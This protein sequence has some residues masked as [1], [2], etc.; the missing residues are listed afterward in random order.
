MQAHSTL[1]GHARRLFGSL[2]A[3]VRASGINFDKER[4]QVLWT[5]EGV[6]EWIRREWK[7]GRDIRPGIT[8]KLSAGVFNAAV[9]EFGGWYPAIRAAKIRG[10]KEVRLRKWTPEGLIAALKTY[11]PDARYDDVERKDPGLASTLWRTFGGWGKA[12]LAAGYPPTLPSRPRRW[13]EQV[14]LETIRERGRSQPRLRTRVFLD[15]GG[16]A[17]AAAAMFGSWPNAVRA[18]GFT[19]V[20]GPAWGPRKWTREAILKA[21][22]DKAAAGPSLWTHDVRNEGGALYDVARRDFGGWDTALQAAGV[23]RPVRTSIWSKEK[24]IAV[25]R[26]HAR[27]G[28]S[29]RS[30]FLCKKHRGLRR[31]LLDLFDSWES[32][33]QAA[34][35]IVPAR[36]WKWPKDRALA[37]LVR[38]KKLGRRIPGGLYMAIRY[39][40]GGIK[41]ALGG[42][43]T[44]SIEA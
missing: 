8:K 42:S 7:K 29:A 22:Q 19:Y 5:R 21:I 4:V 44:Q 14:L 18:A 40:F 3:A 36:Q 6:L 39:Q 37:E 17:K 35:L 34:G 10:F 12:R 33:V 27:Q 9:R 43:G 25:L 24:V 1:Y 30:S 13:T 15:L 31:A 28:L 26:K 16:F 2:A 20:E 23:E 38:L 11:G 41:K 32:A